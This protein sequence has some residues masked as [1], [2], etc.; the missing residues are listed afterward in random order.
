MRSSVE[1]TSLP[2]VPAD[3]RILY[4]D[5]CAFLDLVRMP[6]RGDDPTAEFSAVTQILGAQNILRLTAE[7][8]DKEFADNKD[9]VRTEVEK[10]VRHFEN[11]AARV[12]SCMTQ[13]GQPAFGELRCQGIDQAVEKCAQDALS[14]FS[15]VQETDAIGLRANNREKHAIGPA[16]KGKACL[17]DCI[18]V[19][20]L[21]ELASH[22]LDATDRIVFLTS[23]T[24]DFGNGAGGLHPDL[25]VDFTR[26]KIQMVSRWSWA[27][28]SL[29]SP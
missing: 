29:T 26:L 8:V 25:E 16:Q 9:A 4:V 19:E 5:T 18:V 2:P 1:L 27:R 10:H 15:P 21:L 17:K 6:M 7:I 20:T 12:A 14:A 22:V 11:S 3:T 13:M 24:S 28:H 23:N